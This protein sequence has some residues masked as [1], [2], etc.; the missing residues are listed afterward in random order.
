MKKICICDYNSR[1]NIP[2]PVHNLSSEANVVR[3]KK[4]LNIPKIPDKVLEKLRETLEKELIEEGVCSLDEADKRAQ[5]ILKTLNVDN[6]TV[7]D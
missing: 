5:E 1:E 2:C 6:N 3:P 7:I 4:D